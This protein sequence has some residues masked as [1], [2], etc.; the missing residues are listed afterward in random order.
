MRNDLN[1]L[2]AGLHNHEARSIARAISLV[3]NDH[4]AA[5]VILASLDQHHITSSQ[6]LGI[7][8]SPGVGK[9]TL[10]STLVR[11]FRGQ[12]KRVGIVAVDPS[13]SITGGALLGD[14][15]RMMGHA[16]DPDVVVRSMATRGRLGGLCAAAGAAVRIMAASGCSPVIIETVGVG[17]SEMDIIRLA[18]LTL[19][20][21]APGMGDEIQAMKAGILEVADLLVVNK[22]DCLGAET[23]TMDLE[24]ALRGKKN[25]WQSRVYKTV[26]T[27]GQGIDELAIA[28]DELDAIYRSSG[29][30]DRRR[31]SSL[32]LETV[33]WAV[34]LLKPRL[35]KEL[36][37]KIY[38]AEPRQAARKL[39]ARL[40]P[41]I[42]D[43]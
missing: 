22:T 30:H 27:T 1:A 37:E 41:S 35:L 23:L 8:G 36:Q 3:E 21:L 5:E 17:Q 33:D 12:G 24:A 42:T 18:D 43:T 4:E 14:R 32:E 25:P 2:L 40:C 28:I 20:V 19:M 13:S 39:L 38:A 15:V 16:L 26:A 29:E 34:E 11:H 31:H 10:T 9:S 6:V 7:T